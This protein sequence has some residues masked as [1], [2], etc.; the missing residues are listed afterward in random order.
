[1]SGWD[2]KKNEIKQQ[3]ERTKAEIKAFMGEQKYN[4]LHQVLV[5]HRSQPVPNEREMFDDIK[6]KMGGIK[7]YV[8][9]AFRLDNI[10]FSELI[11][12]Q[13]QSRT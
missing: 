8:D 1:M 7:E 4:E 12:E 3:R 5:Y 9:M 11:I 10:V 6:T 2:L 13:V